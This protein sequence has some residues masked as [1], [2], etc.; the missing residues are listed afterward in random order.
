MKR[1]LELPPEIFVMADKKHALGED[2]IPE[3]LVMLKDYPELAVSRQ[4]PFKEN[5]YS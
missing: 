4:T 2:F 5:C 3:D 1:V